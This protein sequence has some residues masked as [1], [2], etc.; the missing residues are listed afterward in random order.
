MQ[1]VISK[2]AHVYCYRVFL[3]ANEYSCQGNTVLDDGTYKR[4]LSVLI[5][6]LNNF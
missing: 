6:I 3:V 1:H 4:T 2:F 5:F